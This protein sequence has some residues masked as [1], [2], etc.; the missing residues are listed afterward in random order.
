MT[1]IQELRDI[2]N[3]PAMKRLH[4]SDIDETIVDLHEKIEDMQVTIAVLELMKKA[5]E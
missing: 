4:I 3:M 5:L 2:R 1:E